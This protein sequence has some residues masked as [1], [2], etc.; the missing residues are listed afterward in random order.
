[1]VDA[2]IVDPPY[3]SGGLHMGDRT[4]DPVTKY[5]QTGTV[6][7]KASFAGDQKDQR[8]WVRWTTEWLRECYRVMR[9]G[10]PFAIF[11][12][13]RQLPS[14]T[15]AVQ[16]ADLVWRGVAVWD[17]TES[18]RPQ[19]GRPRSQAEYVVWGSK[20]HLSTK[21]PAPV[22]PGVFCERVRA[23]DKHH[24]TGKPVATMRWLAGLCDEGG[25]IL[26]PFTGSAST[27]VGALLEGRRFLGIE[28]DPGCCEIGQRR[29]KAA[30]DGLILSA[31]QTAANVQQPHRR[32][33]T[34]PD[35]TPAP[36]SGRTVLMG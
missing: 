31:Q 10:A 1:M 20:G 17:K 5:E 15:D 32:P 28:R 33:K 16:M 25:L 19:P 9:P 4:R 29:L 36:G 18:T 35:P 6:N 12:D 34:K 8:G 13:W 23:A 21:R 14:L 2:L 7:S 22:L 26:D 11:I 3:C 24:L 30:A 27:G